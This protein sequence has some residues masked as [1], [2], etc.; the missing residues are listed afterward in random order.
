MT[1]LLE[2]SAPA[3]P[4]RPSRRRYWARRALVVGVA[5]LIVAAVVMAVGWWNSSD[6][7]DVAAR[8]ATTTVPRGDAAGTTAPSTTA[9]TTAPTTTPTTASTT[10]APGPMP[11][12]STEGA[13][14]P[15]TVPP[16]AAAATPVLTPGLTVAPLQAAGK[17][18]PVVH[19]V[20][21]FDPVV[22]ITIDDGV[23]RDPAVAEYLRA[24]N[25]P[26]TMFL[27]EQ[28][29][30]GGF[31]FFKSLQDAGAGVAAHSISHVSL[32]GKDPA[33]QIREVCEPAATY[34]RDFAT[35]VRYF[36]PPY[37]NYDDT[38]LSAA[39]GC[40]MKAVVHWSATLEDAKLQTAS[41]GPLRAG[42]IVLLHFKPS[43]LGDLQ[44]LMG[45]LQAL[46][47]RPALLENYLDAANV[48]P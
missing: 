35:P 41:G 14:A 26:V 39:A 38:T 6:T 4:P 34:A 40:G 18:L 23:T 32:R 19:R 22:F 7:T 28:Y 24:N 25:I 9:S 46:G 1:S 43:L 48:A 16:N 10:A 12:G 36:R 31:P 45:Q 2:P 13:P 5:A 30:R 27:T 20:I 21:T 42:D 37:G 3:R 33:T 8:R 11:A 47:L 29:M 17:P 44:F 15:E